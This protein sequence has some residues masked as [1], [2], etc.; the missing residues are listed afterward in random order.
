VSLLGPRQ[1]IKLKAERAEWTTMIQL[2]EERKPGF[3]LAVS[4][5]CR[6][7]RAGLGICL[8]QPAVGPSFSF[9]VSPR[10]LWYQVRQ[11]SPSLPA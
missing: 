4:G 9:R 2:S 1:R 3:Q 8:C 5:Y 7:G 6:A 11:C 10:A